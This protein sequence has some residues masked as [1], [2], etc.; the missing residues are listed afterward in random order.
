MTTSRSGVNAWLV[1]YWELVDFSECIAA[2]AGDSKLL[3]SSVIGVTV[4]YHLCS[5]SLRLCGQE[6]SSASHVRYVR[7]QT[8]SNLFLLHR[9]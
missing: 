6:M 8:E 9:Q 3:S 4:Q 2:L 5:R 7:L 1:Q